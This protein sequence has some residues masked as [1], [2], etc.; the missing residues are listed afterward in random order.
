M[1]EQPSRFY[2][3]NGD[4]FMSSQWDGFYLTNAEQARMLAAWRRDMSDPISKSIR[5]ELADE[6]ERAM[7]EAARQKEH[8][9]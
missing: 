5:A 3:E 4:V 2:A 9:K 8:L 7:A 1:T 6:L